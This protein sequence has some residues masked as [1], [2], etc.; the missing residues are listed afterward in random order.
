MMT[1][2]TEL[3]KNSKPHKDKPG[4]GAALTPQQQ[5]DLRWLKEFREHLEQERAK[6]D[7]QPDAESPVN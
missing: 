4:T 5:E 3:K 1:A 2:K 7:A 6:I